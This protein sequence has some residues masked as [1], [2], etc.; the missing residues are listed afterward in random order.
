MWAVTWMPK[1]LRE[2]EGLEQADRERVVAKLQE[3]LAD[4]VRSFHRLRGSPWS[5]LRVGDHRV[6]AVLA[7][8]ARRLE[9]HAV[10]H[11][12]TAYGR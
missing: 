2:L 9:V 11:R 8:R 7:V 3:A 4:P 5:R 1:A 12:S 6:F 10:R